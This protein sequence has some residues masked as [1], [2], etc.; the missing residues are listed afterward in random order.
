MA[1]VLVQLVP[2][3]T[4]LAG[5]GGL[6]KWV[7]SKLDSDRKRLDSLETERDARLGGLEARLQAR[8]AE[9]TETIRAL[10]RAETM[11]ESTRHDLTR[12]IKA[13]NQTRLRACRFCGKGGTRVTGLDEITEEIL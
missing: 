9:Y 2:V 1:D 6:W 8:D 4:V 12:A 7:Q 10:A 11:L 13:L 5:L 3:V